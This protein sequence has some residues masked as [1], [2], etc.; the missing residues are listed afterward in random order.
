VGWDCEPTHAQAN[1]I[2]CVHRL[3]DADAA[4]DC[5]YCIGSACE[6]A[7]GTCYT[8]EPCIA[9]PYGCVWPDDEFV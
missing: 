9:P 5:S 8:P 4:C 1:Y 2:G 3:C 6:P 7:L